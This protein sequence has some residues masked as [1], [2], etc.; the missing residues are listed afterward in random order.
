MPA[1]ISLFQLCKSAKLA[2]SMAVKLKVNAMANFTLSH[3]RCG[4]V[5]AAG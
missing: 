2:I 5:F 4:G 3:S 1:K